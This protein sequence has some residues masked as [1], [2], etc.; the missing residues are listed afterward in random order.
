MKS[1]TTLRRHAG[2][3]LVEILIAMLI[4]LI[5]VVV[6]M[7]VYA[8]SEGYKRT[9]TSGS[10]AQVN[11][12][13]A[14]Y[15]LEREIRNA[16]FN[17]MAP[18]AAGC[19]AATLWDGSKGSTLTMMLSPVEIVDPAVP[20]G[21]GIPAGDAGSDIIK[22][23][24]GSADSFVP[25]ARG[26]QS[27][28]T[29]DLVMIDNREGFR[30][31]DLVLGVMP[32]AGTAGGY[33]CAFHELTKVPGAIENCSQGL[34]SGGADHL[35]I[36]TAGYKNFS[37]NCASVAPRYNKAT[38][39]ADWSGV[40]MLPVNYAT[41]GLVYNVGVP[42]MKV[43]A[44]RGGNLTVCEF[45]TQD[46]TVAAN[47]TVVAD[48]VVALR[49]L[50]GQ[51]IS[52]T[53]PGGDGQVRQ[54]SH[55]ATAS[56]NEA[57]HAVAVALAIVSRSALPEKPSSGTACDTT[58]DPT[59]P[60]KAMTTAWYSAYAPRVNTTVASDFDLSNGGRSTG[61]QCYRYRLFQTTVP[62]RNSLWRP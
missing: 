13:I 18:I 19:R 12:G 62:L 20:S 6:I 49:A 53:N 43:F 59:Q 39:M 27:S 44:V 28:A 30:S 50:I 55:G 4:A 1:A 29:A 41:G 61:W 17:L 14:L 11:G 3:T 32:N 26:T 45:F 57:N 16:G 34:P 15:M 10:D 36:S 35:E 31:G 56:V 38:A 22:V 46:C 54:W 42:Q 47:Y 21:M 48:N 60:D 58:A 33:Q 23:T 37:A 52:A 8:V 2:F 40:A 24:Y 51:D 9:A 7:Q 5:G 25:G